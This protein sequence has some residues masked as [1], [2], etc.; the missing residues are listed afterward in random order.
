[1][2]RGKRRVGVF[3]RDYSI[4]FGDT[5]GFPGSVSHNIYMYEWKVKEVRNGIW[6]EVEA[7]TTTAEHVTIL[8]AA[9]G[10]Q[11][12]TYLHFPDVAQRDKVFQANHILLYCNCNI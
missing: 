3:S 7:I 10:T 1:M 9:L 8:R 6:Y 2:G 4:S 5:A 11:L 12:L